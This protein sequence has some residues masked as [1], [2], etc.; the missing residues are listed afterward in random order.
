MLHADLVERANDG[1]LEQAPDVFDAVRMNV[2]DNPLVRR[3]V[4]GFVARVLVSDAH[5]SAPL[6][7]VER[8]GIVASNRLHEGVKRLFLGVRHVAQ[9]NLAVPL[10]RASNP[11]AIFGPN[12]A[13]RTRQSATAFV[14]A[15][16]A[17]TRGQHRL[18]QFD[19]AEQRRTFV[20][21]L[22]RFT[23]AMAE[24]PR[25]LVRHAK[26]ALQ[27]IRAHGLFA[28]D[29]EVRSGEPLPQ[30]KLG[31]VEDRSRRDREAEAAEV[32]VELV[33]GRDARH[34]ITATAVANGPR[35]PTKLL[36][37]VPADLLR[38]KAMHHVDEA[39]SRLFVLH[40]ML[41]DVGLVN[42]IGAGHGA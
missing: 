24:K 34:G 26:R 10:Q 42:R 14:L 32:A 6:I 9:T 35:R 16:T 38:P 7:G 20:H 2:T 21:R 29:H 33:A 4:N 12:A 19:D 37:I 13:R 18:V 15:T 22:H 8:F 27:L 41:A 40:L 30:R 1:T 31:V 5:V 11:R 39:G 25:G 36:Q 17:T 23:D 28:F 3:V